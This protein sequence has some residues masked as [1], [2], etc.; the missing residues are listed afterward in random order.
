MRNPLTICGTRLHFADFAYKFCGLHLHLRIPLTFCGIHQQL[1]NPEQLA[2]LA[3]C[4][5][6]NKTNV[7]TKI[8]L[9]VY[10]CG[11]HWNFVCGV[12]LQ[13]GTYCKTCLWNP[14][15]YRHKIVLLSSAQFGLVKM[16]FFVVR[17]SPY[18]VT[19]LDPSFVRNCNYLIRKFRNF[20][21]KHQKSPWKSSKATFDQ[22]L[23][24][25]D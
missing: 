3:C 23:P 25:T 15:T 13:F 7:P 2:M 22:I 19:V 8:T 18:L 5:I 12:H 21:A 20:K 16:I 14:E 9:Q 4:G 24:S 10:V 6:R 11:I 1:R 17:T